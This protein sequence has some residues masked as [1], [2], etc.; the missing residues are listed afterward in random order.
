[1]AFLLNLDHTFSLHDA[2]EVETVFFWLGN[3]WIASRSPIVAVVS[4][5]PVIP[6]VPAVSVVSVIAITSVAPV[7][8]FTAIVGGFVFVVAFLVATFSPATVTALPHAFATTPRF[9]RIIFLGVVGG[10]FCGLL[11]VGVV[12]F[13]RASFG[14]AGALTAFAF[15]AIAILAAA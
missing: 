6:V 12:A 10:R 3:E 15:G 13:F 9:F 7:V 11:L 2:I 4:I 5:V 8:A 14:L 1:V